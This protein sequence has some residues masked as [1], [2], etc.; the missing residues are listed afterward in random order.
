MSDAQQ[1]AQALE[2]LQGS[3]RVSKMT[4]NGHDQPDAY[5][6]R[7][8]YIIEGDRYRVQMG[9]AI[10]GEGTLWIDPTKTPS[11]FETAP[12]RGQREFCIYKL[13]GDR[14]TVCMSNQELPHDFVSQPGSRQTLL[15][16][17]RECANSSEPH[18]PQ[19]PIE[20]SKMA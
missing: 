5:T 14:L 12:V 9:N 1:R 13:E 6:E 3:W 2:G 18:I 11:I 20:G 8:K 17:A 7:L 10:L 15:V 19:P 16:L 4:W